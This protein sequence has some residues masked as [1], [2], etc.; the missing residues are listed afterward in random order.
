MSKYTTTLYDILKNIVPDSGDL[1]T[2]ELINR[3]ISLFFNFDYPWYNTDKSSKLEFERMYLSCYLTNEI[4]QETLGAHKQYFKRVMY[5]SI[6]EMQQKFALLNNMPDIA[7]A[8]KLINHEFIDETETGNTESSQSV[9]SSDKTT[10][11]QNTQSIHSDNPQVTFAQNDYAS[12]MDRAALT[13]NGTSDSNSNGSS[14]V[15]SQRIG[16][17]KRF[18]DEIETDTRN[19]E[20]YF[21]AIERGVYLINTELVRRCRK[22]F[23]QL[24]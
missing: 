4:G 11:S 24:W 16:N 3:G 7:G 12:E 18:R 22:L 23:M 6:E 19:S 13:G 17:T 15:D 5:E 20:M 14:S 8:R 10:Q 21:S 2:D 9:T 1:S